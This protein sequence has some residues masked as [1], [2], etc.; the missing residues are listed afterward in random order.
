[1]VIFNSY[2]DITRGYS[3]INPQEAG[4]IIQF[5]KKKLTVEIHGRSPQQCGVIGLQGLEKYVFLSWGE[6]GVP[7]VL[8]T[9]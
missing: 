8:G 4:H 1:M 3:N 7:T 5:E 2:F 9:V 6:R